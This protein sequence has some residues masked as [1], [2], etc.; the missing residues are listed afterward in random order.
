[1]NLKL[2]TPETEL[3]CRAVLSLETEDECFAFFE[4]ILTVQEIQSIAQRL[5]VAQMLDQGQ[6]Y[7]D[8]A[9]V[10]GA[11]SAT[12]SRV[13]RALAFGA[14]GYRRVLDKLNSAAQ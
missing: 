1:M 8:I 3:L 11:S 6:T 13:K 10:T 12:I 4:D 14:D 2:K 7:D 5:S 9:R